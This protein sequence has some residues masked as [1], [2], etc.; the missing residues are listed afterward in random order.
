MSLILAVSGEKYDILIW[1][2][3][4]HASLAFDITLEVG[5]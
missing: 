2:N 3:V 4:M 5:M 1:E